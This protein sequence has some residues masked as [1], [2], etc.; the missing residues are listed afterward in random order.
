M[1]AETHGHQTPLDFARRLV[2][3]GVPVFACPPGGTVDGYKLPLAWPSYRPDLGRL[4]VWRPGYAL[5]AVCGTHEGGGIDVIDVDPR[6]GGDL[7]ALLRALGEADAA[8]PPVLAVIGT[9]SG[10]QHLYVPAQG[11]GKGEIFQGVDYQAGTTEGAAGDRGFVWLPGTLRTPKGATEARGY[12]VV[13]DALRAHDSPES[14][15]FKRWVL[16]RRAA[17][18]P[19]RADK[20]ALSDGPVRVGGRDA[21]ATS[22]AASLRRRGFSR[23]EAEVAMASRWEA[24]EQPAGD[25]FEL[26]E[27]LAKLDS[28]WGKFEAREEPLDTEGFRAP[29]LA[30]VP[31][32]T[33]NPAD[34]PPEPERLAYLDWR[35]LEANPAPPV[36]W[37]VDGVLV[38]GRGHLLYSTTGQGKSLLGLEWAATLAKAGRRV[39]YCDWENSPEHDVWPRLVAMGF[40]AEDLEA[41]RYLSFPSFAPLDVTGAQL[42]AAVEDQEVE[43]VVLDTA[44]R[45]I[46]GPE[47]DNDTWNA[48]DRNTGVPLR[49]LGVGFLRMDHAGK[50]VERGA[51]GGSAKG[52][53]VD[54]VWRLETDKDANP[55]TVTLT[56]E[57]ARIPVPFD[58]IMLKRLFTPTMRHERMAEDAQTVRLVKNAVKLRDIWERLDKLGIPEKT[59]APTALARLRA[60]GWTG[61]DKNV[62]AVVVNRQAQGNALYRYPD[63]APERYLVGTQGDGW[64]VG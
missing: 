28:A 46:R 34:A 36:D 9:P 45:T 30:L 11:L 18:K 13:H 2:A 57:K 52:T 3:L 4:A 35:A 58:V 44:S 42:L 64:E 33:D 48:W 63:W 32:T 6:N 56:N 43:F 54:L 8:L 29:V 60:D 26:G 22:Y 25:R 47:N 23:H 14:P 24:Y 62:R 12:T 10:G 59:G 16:E 21:D 49:R 20:P 7:T 1:T 40:K 50:D 17:A 19:A 5:A 38:A 53:D 61:D 55:I 41:L 39:L 37:L 31:P 15:S 27:A 51:R